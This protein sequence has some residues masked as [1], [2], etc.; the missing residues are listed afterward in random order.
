MAGNTTTIDPI[1]D[2]GTAG[3]TS[4]REDAPPA[5]SVGTEDTALERGVERLLDPVEQG[6]V[7]LDTDRRPLFAN[8]RALEILSAQSPED[9]AAV[10]ADSC[11][12]GIFASCSEQGSCITYVD[13]TLPDHETR[14]LLGLEIRWTILPTE[15]EAY[16]LLIHD[17]SRWKQL[18]ELRSRFATS[19]SHRM[20]T[21]LTAIRNAVKILSDQPVESGERERLLDIGWRNVEKLIANLDELQKIFMIESEEVNVCRTLTRVRAELRPIFEQL[22]VE[23]KVRGYKVGVPDMTIFAGKGRLRDFVVTAVE[24]Y[25]TWLSEAPFIECSS[26][27]T[28]DMMY[29]GGVERSLKIYLRPRTTGWVRTVRESL[30]DYLSLHE[31]H[32]GLVLDR[33]ATA[34][35]GRLDVSPGNTISLTLP[36]DPQFDREKDLVSP[37]HMMI[38][39]ADLTGGEFGLVDLRLHGASGAVGARAVAA[40]EKVMNAFISDEHVISR[41]ERDCSWSHFITGRCPDAIEEIMRSIQERYLEACRSSGEEMIPSVHWEI[42]YSRVAGECQ[43]VAGICID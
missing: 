16:Y 34:L 1:R 27:V 4:D 9:A 20:R 36:L 29:H 2:A 7:I 43:P 11:P 30:R 40:L 10:L 17:F 28:E 18:D 3:K 31:A 24:A 22:S 14:K 12:E 42:R 6:I 26:S 21:P 15:C 35:D 32:R 5:R 23:G 13:V 38:E 19:L 41:G 8:R 37:L 33:L 25:R 39:R